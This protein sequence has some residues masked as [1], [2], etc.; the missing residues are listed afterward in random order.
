MEEYNLTL[1]EIFKNCY[2]GGY[3]GGEVFESEKGGEIY[4]DGNSLK[5]EG[6]F[7]VKEKFRYAR[8]L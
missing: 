8:Y 3:I 2:T 4:F 7:N 6:D 1:W 5:G